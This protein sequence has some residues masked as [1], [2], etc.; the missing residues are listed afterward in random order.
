MVRK[1]RWGEFKDE[2]TK[3]FRV[4][5]KKFKPIP[6]R[7]MALFVILAYFWPFFLQI[8]QIVAY[9][10]IFF[11]ANF[12]IFCVQFSVRFRLTEWQG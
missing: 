1:L 9:F 6:L 2:T 8:L 4:A 12:N 11:L 3:V 7:E 5:Y 10:Y